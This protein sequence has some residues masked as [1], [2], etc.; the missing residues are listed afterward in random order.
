MSQAPISPASPWYHFSREGIGSLAR[1]EWMGEWISPE[2]VQYVVDANPEAGSDERLQ[3]YVERVRRGEIALRKAG[4]GRPRSD[5]GRSYFHLR[6]EYELC[7]DDIK[8]MQRE[9]TLPKPLLTFLSPS[10]QAAE[11]IARA[12][13]LPL[14]YRSFANWMSIERKAI[15]ARIERSRAFFM[16]EKLRSC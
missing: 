11:D 15:R 5:L 6:A 2:D 3:S 12:R 14:D 16:N 9:G 7:L 8:Q 13:C 10:Q 1:R 4:K